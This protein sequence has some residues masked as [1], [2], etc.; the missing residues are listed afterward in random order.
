MIVVLAE[1]EDMAAK[2]AGA[3]DCVRLKDGTI[4][5]FKEI[6]K[7]SKNIKSAM[8]K[9]P[10]LEAV[11][12]GQKIL[13]TWAQGHLCG[14]KNAVDYNPDYKMWSNLPVPFIPESFELK[15]SDGKEWRMK[16]IKDLFDKASLVINACDKDREGDT[17]FG[18]I[19]EVCGCKTVYKRARLNEV[20]KDG[21]ISAFEKHNLV[22]AA[23]AEPMQMAGRAR[24]VADWVVGANLTAQMTLKHSTPGSKMT[25]SIGRVQTPVLKIMVDRELAIRN[26][27]SKPFWVIEALFK[28]A[29]G[30][31]FKAVHASERFDDKTV[32]KSILGAITGKKGT[33]SKVDTKS[34][35]KKP[36][37][38]YSTDTLQMDANTAF[39]LT[40]TET[41][42]IL[43][44]LYEGGYTTYPRTD[45]AFLN[46]DMEPVVQ[47]ALN[48]LEGLPQYTGLLSGVPRTISNKK[49]YF[50]S[51]K[52]SGHHAIIPT[53]SVPTSLKGNEEKVYDLIA[54]SIIR[55]I[56][57]SAK[58]ELV[59]AYIDVYG[60][61][62][63]ANGSTVVDMGWLAVGG[64]TK[65]KYLPT[66]VSGDSFDGTYSMREGK[67][68]P[69]KAFTDASLVAAMRSAGADLPDADLRKLMSDPNTGGIG[70]PST[71]NRIPE[72]LIE[73][74]YAE[75]KGKTLRATDMGIKLMSIIPCTELTS[76]E[77]T[78]LWE[79][80]LNKVAD[81][82][83]TYDAF[84]KDIVSATRRWCG[85]ITA[86]VSGGFGGSSGGLSGGS[87]TSLVCPLCGNPVRKLGWGWG[88]SEYK[89][90]CKFSISGTV[91]KKKLTDKQAEA[92]ITK[93][94]TSLIKGFTGSKGKFDAILV[95]D[96]SSGR[97]TFEFPKKP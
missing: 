46:D 59:K 70:R 40:L 1:K 33:V 56:Y 50:N 6:E 25:L 4:Y 88:C 2:I 95:Y 44:K 19:Y 73:R 53:H 94:A 43:Q 47:N 75:R 64:V 81:R 5:Q 48:A 97:I 29:S 63:V 90:G 71:R 36:P 13:I 22:S 8:R 60:E 66:L 27:K 83:D 11:Y 82:T 89:T 10:Y 52:V 30:E 74:G 91:A 20:T 37:S 38:L 28:T 7:Q 3:L 39:G 55:M 35:S 49:D 32:A 61:G 31:E 78:A 84:V 85:D 26:F 76:P 87:G 57:P 67:T 21:I 86:Q 51:K 14:L 93:G 80:R 69:P 16:V 62:F 65:E 15:I 79:T 9:M 18:Y 45:S 41:Q 34:Y 92:L 17:I 42:E 54:K 23:D 68:I 72:M 58:G 12:K 77:L 96:K 24:A